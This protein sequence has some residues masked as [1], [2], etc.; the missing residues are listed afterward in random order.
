M[1]DLKTF[2]L[3]LESKALQPCDEVPLFQPIS[4]ENILVAFF[5]LPVG[6]F[7]A[8]ITFLLEKSKK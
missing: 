7:L 8:A 3:Q 5:I 6:F 2:V 1:V 4:Y